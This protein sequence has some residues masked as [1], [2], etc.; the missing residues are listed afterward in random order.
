M[1]LYHHL[2]QLPIFTA[3][4][5]C[6]IAFICVLEVLSLGWPTL[7]FCLLILEIN[8][9]ISIFPLL[10]FVPFLLDLIIVV[11][12]VAFN[13]STVAFVPFLLDLI[14]VVSLVAFVFLVEIFTFIYLFDH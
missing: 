13:I 1:P 14:I 11:S 5:I 8:F 9:E 3:S 4:Q 12:L 6:T 2:V 10:R 7:S